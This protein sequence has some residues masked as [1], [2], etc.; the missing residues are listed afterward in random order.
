MRGSES[1]TGEAPETEAERI[2]QR[3]FDKVGHFFFGTYMGRRNTGR[4]NG[5]DGVQGRAGQN[6]NGAVMYYCSECKQPVTFNEKLH[7]WV[8]KNGE[9]TATVTNRV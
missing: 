9:P 3:K 6:R 4:V 7:K 1:G 5:G 8:H 2:R